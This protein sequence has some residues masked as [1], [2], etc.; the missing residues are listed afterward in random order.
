M[1]IE[2]TVQLELIYCPT[3]PTMSVAYQRTER[4][5]DCPKC[6]RRLFKAS[7]IVLRPGDVAHLHHPHSRLRWR[8]RLMAWVD[9][10][11]WAKITPPPMKPTVRP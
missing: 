11:G 3:C 10:H 8:W 2:D 1:I 6:K 4:M 9:R 7:D 5:G